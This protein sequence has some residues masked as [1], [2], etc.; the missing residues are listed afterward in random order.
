MNV[1][2]CKI[3]LSPCNRRSRH[4]FLVECKKGQRLSVEVEAMRLG[5]TV[6]DPYVAILDARRFELATSDDSPLI[7]QDAGCSIVVPADGKYIVQIRE[8]A[9]GGNGACQYRL[10]VGHFPR[11][12]AVV[13]AGGKPGEELDVTFLGDPAGPIKQKVKL[14][15]A[16]TDPYWRLHCQTA[17]G[18]NPTGF[19]FRIGDL[20]NVIET[21]NNNTAAT[22]TAGPAA[23]CAFN[24]VIAKPGEVDYFKFTAKKGE[25]FDVRCH[26]RQIGSP[27]DSVMNFGRADGA[28]ITGND[29]SGGP[30][31]YFRISIP[32]DGTYTVR[33]QDHLK[34]GGPDYF[35]RIE[36]TRVQAS[37]S[38]T[39]PKVDGNNPANQDRQS[40]AVPRGNRFAALLVGNRAGFGGP[41]A[42]T[43]GQLPAGLAMNADAMD[44][45]LNVVPV[46]FEAKADAAIGGLLTTIAATP[47]DPKVKV[48]SH[49][50]FDAAF[51]LG[52]PGQTIY[53]RHVVEKAAVAVTEAAPFSIEVLEPKV[54]LVQ[55]GSYNLRI[56]AKR[57]PG[58]TGAITVYPLWTPPGMGIASAATIA[59]TAAESTLAMNAASNAV[60]RKWKTAIIAVGDAGKG[61]VWV[62][63]QLFTI[64]IAP[65][66]L[67]L[68]MERPAVEQGQKTQ[69]FC[70][71][72]VATPFEGKAKVKILGLPAKVATTELELT[73]DSKEAAFPITADK[74]SPAGKHGGIFAQVVIEKNGEAITLSTGATELRIDVPL[75]PKAAVAGKPGPM[76]KPTPA[77]P[78]APM[79]RLTRLEK[80]R[81]EQEERE[82]AGTPGKK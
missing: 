82:K 56:A 32:A 54:P 8:S 24:G 67:T 42:M 70:K 78:A 18:I 16:A 59:P 38:T 75:P 30:D 21:A 26:A 73:K 51:A 65:P 22:A 40:I 10:H 55:N 19:K 23:P 27:L 48:P 79:K 28:A 36:L 41:L 43:L 2:I 50:R 74:T 62:S 49:T 63:S 77:N 60:V 64:E 72:A 33:L 80:L 29:D 44:A 11:S 47:V 14:P 31:S 13:P 35:Y 37:V 5:V 17:D 7:G 61:P 9:Y 57:A 1:R 39:I 15:A 68:T 52:A 34:K 71:V 58:F 53:S 81:L 25:V 20:P 46:V 69:M 3:F 4:Y 12:T 76:A 66:P 6:F 45:G